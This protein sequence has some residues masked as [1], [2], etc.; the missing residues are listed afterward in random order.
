MCSLI[1][2]VTVSSANGVKGRYI[3]FFL[4]DKCNRLL[5]HYYICILPVCKYVGSD[6]MFVL[7]VNKNI[8]PLIAYLLAE[9]KFVADNSKLKVFFNAGYSDE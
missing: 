8:I 1:G 9:K 2:P 4:T 3:F 6:Q 7:L 5:Q